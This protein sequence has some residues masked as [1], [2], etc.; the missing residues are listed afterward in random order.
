M[1][2]EQDRVLDA[3]RLAIRMENEGRQCYLEDA[4]R[5]TNKVG[6]KLLRVL[7]D[8]EDG[9]RRRLEEIYEAIRAR[10][11]WPE[12]EARPDAGRRLREVFNTTC[13]LLGVDVNAADDDFRA[14]AAAV[15]KEK[16]S[17]DYY[18][19][20]GRTATYPAE[21]EFY[22]TVA[23]EE[24]EHELV[25]LDYYEYLKDPAGFFLKLERHSLD[26]A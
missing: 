19:R 2:A 25:L 8:E 7:A 9:H 16:E 20:Q 10:K 6:R 12:A 23:T 17:Y 26:G 22:G 5:S 11:S 13:Q 21:R 14:I 24:R 4:A 18:A 3:L 1:T 15:E